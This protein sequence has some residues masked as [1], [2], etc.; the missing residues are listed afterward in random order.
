MFGMAAP[1]GGTTMTEMRGGRYRLFPGTARVPRMN[2]PRALAAA[3]LAPVLALLPAV[4]LAASPF[5]GFWMIQQADGSLDPGSQVEYRVEK[6]WVTMNSPMGASYRART[7]GSDAAMENDAN[8]TRV[9]VRMPGKSTL[10]QSEKN[11]GKIWRITTIEVQ[12]DGR[13]ARVAWKDLKRNRSGSY[14]LSKQ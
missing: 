6:D 1:N 12:P 7:D 5:D 4:A 13:T 3:L 8:T 9:S 14:V 11:D 2:P 10:I